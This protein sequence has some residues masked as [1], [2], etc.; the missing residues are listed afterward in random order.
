MLLYACCYGLFLSET[1]VN[2]QK[3]E[4]DERRNKAFQSYKFSNQLY[5]LLQTNGEGC[6]CGWYNYRL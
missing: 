3:H 1:R 4:A 5:S 2:N 6:P